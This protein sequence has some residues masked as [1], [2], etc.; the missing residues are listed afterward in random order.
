MNAQTCIRFSASSSARE[1]CCRGSAHTSDY[2]SR[3]R[4]FTGLARYHCDA[5]H[6]LSLL[7]GAG[8]S[9]AKDSGG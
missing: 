3:R 2:N 9:E 1:R 6:C 7:H 4:S 8:N 5:R